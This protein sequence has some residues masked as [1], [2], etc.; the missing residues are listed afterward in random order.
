LIAH[1]KSSQH[2]NPLCRVVPIELVK[3]EEQEQGINWWLCWLKM[4]NIYLLVFTTAVP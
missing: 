2:N 4:K 3:E 1:G